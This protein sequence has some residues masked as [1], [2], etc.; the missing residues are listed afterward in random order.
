M[1]EFVSNPSNMTKHLV[2]IVL[3]LNTKYEE[4]FKVKG[5]F[6]KFSTDFKRDMY[7]KESYHDFYL[8]LK[9]YKLPDF[10][11]GVEKIKLLFKEFEKIYDKI[12]FNNFVLAY[13]YVKNKEL[14]NPI[15]TMEDKRILFLKK[16]ANNKITIDEFNQM[17]GHYGLNAY[18][19]SSK[20]FEEY[21]SKELLSIAKLV[22]KFN[23][24]KK[25]EIENYIK[26]K[27][28]DKIPILIA[29]RELGKYNSLLIIK[30]IRY[31]LLKIAKEKGIKD[32]F[33]RSYAEIIK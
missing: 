32:I 17:F 12:I 19:L 24:K 10:N 28:K 27:P 6:K 15:L 11:K 23:F 13:A 20:R 30:E 26:S 2:D 18:E 16:L 3:K 22:S 1:G 31:E 9:N 29:L 5:L 25:I 21:S 4:K 33:S 14:V 8:F 7:L